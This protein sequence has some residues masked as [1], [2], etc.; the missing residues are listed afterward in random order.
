MVENT[1]FDVFIDKK[2]L[3]LTSHFGAFQQHSQ[4]DQNAGKKC[5]I[6]NFCG[7]SKKHYKTRWN[8]PRARRGK[9]IHLQCSPRRLKKTHQ[10]ETLEN[11]T[12]LHIEI[13]IFRENA[14]IGPKRPSNNTTHTDVS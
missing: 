5:K 13:C 6:W 2:P 7:T 11:T 4:M 8:C 10:E 12:K 9:H 1:F 14:A 3:D